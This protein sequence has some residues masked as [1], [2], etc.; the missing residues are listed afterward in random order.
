MTRRRRRYSRRSRQN[1][2][3]ALRSWPPLSNRPIRCW[4]HQLPWAIVLLVQLWSRAPMPLFLE[5]DFVLGH[6]DTNC[7]LFHQFCHG[8]QYWR[9]ESVQWRR[10]IFFWC[11][12]A[13]SD[14]YF[15]CSSL[16]RGLEATHFLA[17][18]KAAHLNGL[19]VNGGIVSTTIQRKMPEVTTICLELPRKTWFLNGC[20]T[21]FPMTSS[22]SVVSLEPIQDSTGTSAYLGEFVRI[23]PV[24]PG[25]RSL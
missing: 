6:L 21:L 2:R 1:Q 8:C 4:I 19:L 5:M 22:W 16:F 7:G 12:G 20:E 24:W 14:I 11:T 17:R 3:L 23:A 18:R 10:L 15:A 13:S 9:T 25:E